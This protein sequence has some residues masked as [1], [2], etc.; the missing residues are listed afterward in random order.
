[1][2]YDFASLSHSQFEDLCRD[3]IGAELGVR[4]EAFPE[5]P[6]DGMDGRHA[7]ADGATI[8]QAKHYLR[9]GAGK[10]L[11]KMKAERASIDALEPRRYILATSAT[12]TP[13]NKADLASA[14]GP[15]LH[16]TGEI[17][18]QGDLNALLRKFPHI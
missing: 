1:M 13:K 7:A 15:A 16:S 10:L 9:S 2:D 14:I 11:T 3:L 12:L 4:F 5:G 8:L 6:D 18:G 17:F